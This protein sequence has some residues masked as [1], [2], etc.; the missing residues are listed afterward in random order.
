M[1]FSS[2]VIPVIFLEGRPSLIPR[3]FA[4]YPFKISAENK[5]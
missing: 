3:Y 2:C 5:G 4:K 1:P